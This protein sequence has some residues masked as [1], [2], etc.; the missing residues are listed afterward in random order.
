MTCTLGGAGR[1][2]IRLRISSLA[3]SFSLW[4][5]GPILC[6][7]TLA[8]TLDDGPKLEA[9]P[10]YTSVQRNDALISQLK[11]HQVQA[12]FFVTVGNGADRPEGLDLLKALSDGGQLLANHTLHHPDFN[13]AATTLEAFEGEIAGCDRVISTLP[14]YRKFLRFPFLREGATEGKRDGIRAFLKTLGYHIGYVSI[15]TCDWLI[16]EKLR[17][18]LE[19]EPKADLAPWRAFYLAHLWERAQ[20]YDR[21]AKGIYGREVAHT[22][23]L[24]HNLLNALF[25]GDVIELFRAK[26]WRFVSPDIAFADQAYAVAPRVLPLDGSVLETTAEA[27]GIELGPFFKGITSERRVG[28][29]A[30]KL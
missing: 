10:L 11:R 2:R 23:L 28:E 26:G 24:H 4:G 22:I 3:F 8:L 18:K 25:L 16:D 12:M 1:G 17:R 5:L 14:G 21:L 9:T 27:L 6:A 7:Q 19:R 30:E 20:I 29:L 13:A 15:D